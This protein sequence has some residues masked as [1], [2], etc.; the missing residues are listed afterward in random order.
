MTTSRY[1][2]RHG[3]TPLTAEDR[4]SGSE[5]VHLSEEGHAQVTRLA[6]RLKEYEINAVFCSPLDITLDITNVIVERHYITPITKHGLREITHSHWE[7]M[8]RKEVEVHFLEEY[9]SSESD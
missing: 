7:G 8:S 5:N 2:D 3:S 9:P 4:C 1:L 6:Q